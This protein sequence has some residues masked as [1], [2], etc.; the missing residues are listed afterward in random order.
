[1]SEDVTDGVG[2]PV[3]GQS[4]FKWLAL[5]AAAAALGLLVVFL[6]V[7]AKQRDELVLELGKGLIQLLVVVVLGIALKL[8][9]DRY[10]DEQ[11]RAEQER[12]RRQAKEDQNR[13]FRQDKYDRLV[14]ATNELRRVPILINANR[15][16]KTWSEQML[17]VIDAGLTLRMIKHQIYSSRGL[18]DP[19]F[20][21]YKKLV[22][23]FEFMY[24]YTDWVTADFADRKKELSE[25]QRQAEKSDLP[26]QDRARRQEAVWD[27]IQKLPSVADMCASLLPEKRESLSRERKNYRAS[28]E[29]EL[30]ALADPNDSSTSPTTKAESWAAYEEAESLAL[31]LITQAT[32]TKRADSHELSRLPG[33]TA[34]TSAPVHCPAPT[35]IIATA[36]ENPD[37]QATLTVRRRLPLQS[38]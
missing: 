31:E 38:F 28:I 22:Y 1:L 11:Q 13:Q 5:A 12:Q 3:R 24:Q 17:A 15:S 25:L 37:S 9:V 20:P 26:V 23:L 33:R 35:T 10:Q 27:H 8:L 21:D 32:L 14:Q 6:A 18:D 19:P 16:V 4:L 36:F 2:E 34:A 29:R 7:G 30:A